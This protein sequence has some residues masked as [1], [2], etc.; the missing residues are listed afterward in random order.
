MVSHPDVVTMIE[1]AATAAP[2]PD[3]AE[4]LDSR[5]AARGRADGYPTSVRGPREVA[6]DV[7]LSNAVRAADAN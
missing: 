5:T 3:Q 6:S 7:Y 4:A 2:A 1:T